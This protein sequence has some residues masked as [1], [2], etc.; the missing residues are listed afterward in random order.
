MTQ[1]RDRVGL[2]KL[3]WFVVVSGLLI[4][5]CWLFLYAGSAYAFSGKM[6]TP[7]TP[8]PTVKPTPQ[9]NTANTLAATQSNSQDNIIVT[10]LIALLSGSFGAIIGSL[11]QARIN[12]SGLMRATEKQVQSLFQATEQQIKS[13]YDQEKENREY[14][15]KRQ[16]EAIRN[17]LLVEIKENWDLVSA[18]DRKVHLST[19]AWTTYKGNIAVFSVPL[20][21]ELIKLY[22]KAKR[23]NSVLQQVSDMY[24]N[25]MDNEALFSVQDKLEK[26]LTNICSSVLKMLAEE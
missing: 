2:K 9:I 14:A 8:T 22:A 6:S 3:V 25:K 10:I 19:E 4:A 13:L 11:I 16:K 15:E 23:Y 24:L 20:Q 18:R 7:M 17:S 21:E 5:F 26:E 12:N 1:K